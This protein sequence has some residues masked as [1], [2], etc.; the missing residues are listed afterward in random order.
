[1][2]PQTSRLRAFWCLFA[3][4]ITLG[5]TACSG[6][7]GESPTPGHST[8]PPAS[9]AG[10]ALAAHTFLGIHYLVPEGWKGQ[11]NR[12]GS[13]DGTAIYTAPDMRGRVSVEVNG[14]IACVDEGDVTHALRNQVPDPGAVI[15]LYDPVSRHRV[16]V[17]TIA[18]TTRAPAQY[19]APAKLVVTKVNGEITGYVV[20]EAILPK[21]QAATAADIVAS[22]H[23]KGI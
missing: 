22:L 2:I 6:S 10:P 23:G 7:S 9:P 3:L 8:S 14:C 1:V 5:L 21:P 20:I 13:H 12:S 11:R 15:K 19:A 18:F 17:A 4:L 16:N